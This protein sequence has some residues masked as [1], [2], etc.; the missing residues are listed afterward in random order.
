M[1]YLALLRG[2]NVGGNNIIKNDELKACFEECGF[3][4][5]VTYI[6]SGNILFTS[7]N[8][9]IEIIKEKIKKSLYKKMG[10]DIP[11]VIY[12]E[13]TYKEII[14]LAPKGWGINLEKKYNVL[15]FID[16]DIGQESFSSLPPVKQGEKIN[17]TEYAIF[18]EVLKEEYNAS[19]YTRNLIKHPLYKQVTIRNSN[20]CFK[21]LDLFDKL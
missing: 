7:E 20:T 21:L 12:S 15:F 2:I 5:V 4:N 6:Q 18:W 16:K 13:K 8:R 1:K 9:S 11:V 17:Q 19:S 3:D 10:K 14:G